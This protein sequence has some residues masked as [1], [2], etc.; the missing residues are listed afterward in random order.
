MTMLEIHA[1]ALS[2]QVAS[3][4][5]F[6]SRYSTTAKVVYGFVEGKDDPCFYRGFIDHFLPDDW[7][8]ELWPAG[9]RDQVYRV[10]ADMNWQRF[11]KERV[12]FFVDRDLSSLIPEAL[13][14]D[15]N[16]YVT[17]GYS[18]ENDLV[19]RGACRRV[20]SE[21]CALGTLDHSE[22]DTVCDLFEVELEKFLA[23]MIPTMA[24]ILH[25]RRSGER[26][27]LNNLLMCDL[28][29]VTSGT[30]RANPTPRGK[31]NPVQY[32]HERCNV[33][34]DATVDTAPLEAEFRKGGAYRHFTR[35]KYVFWFLIEFCRSVRAS[36]RTH[37]KSCT[38]VPPMNVSFAAANGMTI[39]GNRARVPKSL[40][41]FL[42][43]NYCEYIEAKAA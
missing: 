14:T 25:W 5:E 16:I 8:V 34:Y 32:I 4:H 31:G 41:T 30:L 2:A 9:N 40:K 11:P 29:A 6:L 10:H 43:S 22:L 36:I 23:A 12:C 13:A 18:I 38:K 26:P 17:D 27:A 35:G 42:S 33:T 28:F 3:Y 15:S 24:W 21:V 39:I 1:T 19:K 20:L 7:E 37:F